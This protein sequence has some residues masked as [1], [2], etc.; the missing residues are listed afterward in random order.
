MANLPPFR[1][2]VDFP[3][4]G[5]PPAPKPPTIDPKS[6]AAAIILAGK[7]RRGEARCVIPEQPPEA[8]PISDPKAL[9]A[10]IIASGK[11]RRGEIR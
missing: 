10:Q 11:R 7:R 8:Q 3:N 4:A 9:A 1:T 6:T 5:A 2:S